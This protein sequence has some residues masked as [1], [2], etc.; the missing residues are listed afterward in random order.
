MGFGREFSVRMID[1]VPRALT[2]SEERVEAEMQRRLEMFEDQVV[3]QMGQFTTASSCDA[4][5]AV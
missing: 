2:A 1:S 5:V 3:S 4:T